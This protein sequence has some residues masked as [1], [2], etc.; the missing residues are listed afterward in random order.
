[1]LLLILL[2]EM[3]YYSDICFMYTITQNNCIIKKKIFFC[4]ILPIL[5]LILF[6]KL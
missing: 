2:C 5:I 4:F 3:V 6:N 1:M